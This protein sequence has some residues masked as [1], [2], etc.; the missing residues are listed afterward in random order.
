MGEQ[1]RDFIQTYEEYLSKYYP[2][3]SATEKYSAEHT[4]ELA[5]RM[6]KETLRSASQKLRSK[7]A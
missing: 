6:A 3:R 1:H 2:A 5:A 4:K 7:R